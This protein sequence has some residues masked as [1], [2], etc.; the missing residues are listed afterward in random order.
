MDASSGLPKPSPEPVLFFLCAGQRW[1]PLPLHSGRFWVV[2]GMSPCLNLR[3]HVEKGGR[4]KEP[5]MQ[6]MG[7]QASAALKCLC[8]APETGLD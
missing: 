6:P 5:S 8:P 2:E 1:G 4:H 7:R 3:G